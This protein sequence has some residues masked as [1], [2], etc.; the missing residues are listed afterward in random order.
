M[1][2]YF[3]TYNSQKFQYVIWN[4]QRVI[5]K[6]DDIDKN[7][8]NWCKVVEF[9]QKEYERTKQPLEI[10]KISSTNQSLEAI[11]KAVEGIRKK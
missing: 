6:I 8:D 7:K 5:K 9:L 10:H 1:T 4:N 2:Q 11:M 3:L